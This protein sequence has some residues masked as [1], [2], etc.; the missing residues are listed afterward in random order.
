LQHLKNLVKG[1]PLVEIKLPAVE[2][3]L[4]EAV[5]NV[6]RLRKS[7]AAN[8]ASRNIFGGTDLG[9]WGASWKGKLFKTVQK[10]KIDWD[11]VN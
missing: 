7:E 8:D 10:L 3:E 5:G 2:H 1:W 4:V 9:V 11:V 6:R